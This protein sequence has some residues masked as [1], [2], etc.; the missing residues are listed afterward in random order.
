MALGTPASP[1]FT[2][3]GLAAGLVSG[4]GGGDGAWWVVRGGQVCLG[5]WNGSQAMGPN[6][7]VVT[8]CVWGSAQGYSSLTWSVYLET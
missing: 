1:G 7:A 4:G 6:P 5:R 2:G 8:L 3:L